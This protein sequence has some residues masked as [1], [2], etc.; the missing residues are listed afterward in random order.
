VID[1]IISYLQ[2]SAVNNAS[3]IKTA[4]LNS[5]FSSVPE[6]EILRIREDA[7][8]ENTDM[9]FWLESFQRIKK[10]SRRST[11]EQLS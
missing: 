1:L 10:T 5:R 4:G 2:E 3:K 6:S 7:V 11:F 9:E 8:P